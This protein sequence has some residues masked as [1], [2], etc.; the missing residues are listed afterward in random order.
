MLA[1]LSPRR[2]AAT[3]AAKSVTDLGRSNLTRRTSATTM[4]GAFFVPAMRYGGCAWDTSRCAGSRVCRSANLRTVAPTSCLAAA[5]DDS[6]THGVSPMAPRL[7]PTRIASARAAAHRAM[8]KAAL[9]S[10]SSAAVRLKRYNQHIE[11]AHH[12]ESLA[13]GREVLS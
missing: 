6:T 13:A 11:K 9:F 7:F 10:N 5:G 4:M 1:L 2:Y 3:V 8:A 12:L